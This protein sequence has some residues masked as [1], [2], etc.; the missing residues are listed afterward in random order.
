L[1]TPSS[2]MT[3]GLRYRIP[4][5]SATPTDRP[6]LVFSEIVPE[7]AGSPAG[8]KIA[9]TIPTLD[10]QTEILQAMTAAPSGD[11]PGCQLLTRITT[12]AAVP[13]PPA[14]AGA[15]PFASGQGSHLGHTS[16]TP[17][18]KSPPSPPPTFKPASSPP[19]TSKPASSTPTSTGTLYRQSTVVI[20]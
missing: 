13:V 17:S 12:K 3:F 10:L 5:T 15:H 19:P 4:G 1:P 8:F 20:D 9:L 14:T 11:D 18:P 16:P 2:G 7:P 6:D